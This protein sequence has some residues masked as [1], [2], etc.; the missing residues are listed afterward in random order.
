[1]NLSAHP[2]EALGGR[3]RKKQHP[4]FRN[5]VKIP[6]L[7]STLLGA[8]NNSS[9]LPKKWCRFL[10]PIGP[11]FA[12]LHLGKIRVCSM[13]NVP[14]RGQIRTR[15]RIGKAAS[16]NEPNQ[17]ASLF[18]HFAREDVQLPREQVFT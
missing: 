13:L 3:V 8:H 14:D 18:I 1:M 6:N 2:L 10:F 16:P 4:I 7:P 15:N 17:R 11:L 12:F 5:A 9:R